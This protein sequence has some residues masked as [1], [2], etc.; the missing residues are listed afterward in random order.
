MKT[1]WFEG[2][3][4]PKEITKRKELV[5][6]NKIVLD[7]LVEILYNMDKRAEDGVLADYN[8]PSWAYLQAHKN[9]ERA[10]LKKIIALC[11]VQADDPPRR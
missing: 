11:E 3:K 4:D 6:T 5:L 9:G 1:V 7:I 2:L 10:M 8:S